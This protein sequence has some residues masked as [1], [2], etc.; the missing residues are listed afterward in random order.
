MDVKFPEG[1]KYLEYNVLGGIFD[2]YFFAGPTPAEASRQYVETIGELS[3]CAR[4]KVV[5]SQE[6]ANCALGVIKVTLPRFLIGV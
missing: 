3:V 5:R 1:G 4:E 2:L 6:E